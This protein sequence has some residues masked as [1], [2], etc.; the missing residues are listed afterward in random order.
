MT[1][2]VKLKV[3]NSFHFEAPVTR[4]GLFVCSNRRGG[5]VNGNVE[6]QSCCEDIPRKPIDTRLTG[7]P[8]R[9]EM[10]IHPLS[11]PSSEDGF[12]QIPDTGQ[13][14]S[15]LRG[16][17]QRPESTNPGHEEAL[18]YNPGASAS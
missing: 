9:W 8:L 15:P 4:P 10:G 5:V 16:S 1:R 3:L 18:G 17:G 7:Y 14:T 11:L 13:G 2:H 6:Y 12:G